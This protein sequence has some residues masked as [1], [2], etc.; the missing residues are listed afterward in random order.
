MVG[1]SVVFLIW[2]YVLVDVFV[3][4]V[5]LLGVVFILFMFVIGFIWGKLMW[6]IWWEWDVCLI[7]VFVLFFF[8]LGY[9]VF[10]YIIEN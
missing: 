8:Y 4:L 6:G 5:V 9:I 1:V 3:K 7:F 2:C 10:W